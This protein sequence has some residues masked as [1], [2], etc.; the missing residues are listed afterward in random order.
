MKPLKTSCF[1]NSVLNLEYLHLSSRFHAAWQCFVNFSGSVSSFHFSYGK[2]SHKTVGDLN[3]LIFVKYIKGYRHIETNTECF[4]LY[5]I[6]TH[7]LASV[8]LELYEVGIIISISLRQSALINC[9]KLKC[10]RQALGIAY[11]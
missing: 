6:N 10:C 7:V 2:I 3:D 9:L 11:S 5:L 1:K 4:I 8:S